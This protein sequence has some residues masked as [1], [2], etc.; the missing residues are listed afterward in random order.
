[1]A[2]SNEPE[3]ALGFATTCQVWRGNAGNTLGTAYQYGG[4]YDTDTNPPY[5]KLTTRPTI[6]SGKL[7]IVLAPVSVTVIVF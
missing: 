1:M 5:V 3:S 6:I 7:S 2:E 4:T